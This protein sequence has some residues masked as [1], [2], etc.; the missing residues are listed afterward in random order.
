MSGLGL[1]HRW[2]MRT[3]VNVNVRLI[4]QPGAIAP[5][6][7]SDLSISGAYVRTVLVTQLLSPVRVVLLDRLP[8]GRRAMELSAYVVRRDH[9]GLGLEWKNLAPRTLRR[10][11]SAFAPLDVDATPWPCHLH[12]DMHPRMLNK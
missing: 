7:L 3:P 9:E 12:L 6:W 1:D 11:Y 8:S 10:L 5:G 2:G 4:C